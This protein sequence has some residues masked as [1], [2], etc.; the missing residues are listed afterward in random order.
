MAAPYISQ[1]LSAYAIRLARE[2]EATRRGIVVVG[3]A[4]LLASSAWLVALSLDR[5]DGSPIAVA[6]VRHAPPSPQVTL[7]PLPIEPWRPSSPQGTDP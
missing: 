7:H 4:A 2:Q 1:A 3:T 6:H 5:H